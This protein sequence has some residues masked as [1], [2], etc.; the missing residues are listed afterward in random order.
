MK[1]TL[2]MIK[3][4]IQ[5]KGY[6][7]TII[8]SQRFGTIRFTPQRTHTKAL[9]SIPRLSEY[10]QKAARNTNTLLKPRIAYETLAENLTNNL[11]EL[12][13]NGALLDKITAFKIDTLRYCYEIVRILLYCVVLHWYT[14]IL[15]DTV[16]SYRYCYWLLLLLILYWNTVRVRILE[17]TSGNRHFHD[18]ILLITR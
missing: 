3:R 13:T 15:C 18:K 4:E 17:H 9:E 6:F 16:I 11:C 1:I 2:G 5:I 7:W 12:E 8:G 10:A 14:V